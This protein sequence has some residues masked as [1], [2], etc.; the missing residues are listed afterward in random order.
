MGYRLA[1]LFLALTAALAVGCARES[2]PLSAVAEPTIAPIFNQTPQVQPTPRVV[3]L[4]TVAPAPTRERPTPV[5]TTVDTVVYADKLA[6]GWSVRQSSGMTVNPSATGTKFAGTS[7]VSAL[8]TKGYGQLVF[9]LL[10]GATTVY[11]REKV[12]G[13]RFMVSGG[14]SYLP[15]E[16]LAVTV[17]GSKDY[18][19]Y[20]PGDVSATPPEGRITAEEPLFP[21]TRLYFLG[22]N[23]DIRPGE[24][25]EVIVWLDDHF[26]PDYTYVTGL[27][28]KNDEEY[29][30]SFYVDDVAL[31]TVASE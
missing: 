1:I 13:V 18:S 19:Y 28:I 23:R 16:G 31:I 30:A 29:R 9:G 6:P 20:V 8:P 3:A 5:A 11:T 27:V 4:P 7:A 2:T 10:R 21:E 14:E 22:I 17:Y 15:T 24:W 26:T 25:A 12:L